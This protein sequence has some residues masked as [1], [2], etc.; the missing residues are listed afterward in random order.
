MGIGFSVIWGDSEQFVKVPQGT[1]G[2]T[3]QGWC[4]LSGVLLPA[5]HHL[6]ARKIWKKDEL[7]VRP[8]VSWRPGRDHIAA[9]PGAQ[10]IRTFKRRWAR[11]EG[12]CGGQGSVCSKRISRPYEGSRSGFCQFS[13]WIF[14]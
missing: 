13:Q 1:H 10:E 9:V 8:F 7:G 14:F 11:S 4:Q 5:S 6:G 12:R 2:G 3:G